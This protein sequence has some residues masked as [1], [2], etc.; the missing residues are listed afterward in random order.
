MS[1]QRPVSRRGFLKAVVSLP[2]VGA[3]VA[4]LVAGGQFVYP[5]ASLSRGPGKVAVP[6]TG[7]VKVGGHLDFNYGGEPHTIF[8]VSDQ[9]YV[10]VSRVC[11]HLGC[12]IAWQ[13]GNSFF[14]CPC[15]G[16]RFDQTGKVLRGPA[17]SPLNRLKVTIA[18]GEVFVEGGEA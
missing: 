9:E 4:P 1:Q 16:A 17:T 5:P 18:N 15:H 14:E 7:E 3:L 11:T 8:R 2:V 10:A 12:T 13:D 6:G